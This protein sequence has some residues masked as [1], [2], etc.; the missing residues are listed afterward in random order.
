[1]KTTIGTS[2]LSVGAIAYGCWRFAQNTP[3]RAQ[4][5]LETALGEGMT[6]IDTADIYGFSEPSKYTDQPDGFGEAECVLG[7]VLKTTSSL[8]DE[9]VLATK[10]GIIPP[11]PYDSSYDYLTGALERSLKRLH[12][13]RVDLYMIHRPDIL[14]GFEE[15]GRAL[16][17]L[18]DSDKTRF[19]GLSNFTASQA[20]ALQ[21]HMR[22]PLICHQNEFSAL[23]QDPMFDGIL[24]QC[25]EKRMSL[26]A[27]SPLAG[28]SLGSGKY[29]ER[30]S[31]SRFA[32]VIKAMQILAEKHDVSLT[33]IALA[34]VMRHPASTIAIIGTQSP[35]RIKLAAKATTLNLSS[36]DAYDIVEAWRGKPMP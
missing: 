15:A 4:E 14:T 1:M 3:K 20:S 23:H 36:R 27:W 25:Q 32:R 18:V 24:D 8:R 29:D 12:T 10:G 2:D 26:M 30:F 5:L 33:E 34:F 19:V 35:E 28:G 16:D 17:D 9:M 21:A 11:K 22:A 31:R 6:L 13:D 7:E